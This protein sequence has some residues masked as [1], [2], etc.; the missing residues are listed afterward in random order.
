[1][2]CYSKHLEPFFEKLEIP[3][4]SDNIKDFHVLM[5]R[6]SNKQ[7]CNEV[8]KFI[9]PYIKGEESPEE[10]IQFVERHWGGETKLDLDDVMEPDIPRGP[11]AQ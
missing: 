6:F 8:W 11:R 3:F 7:E 9:K 1:M 2:S 5:Q 4:T 10:L